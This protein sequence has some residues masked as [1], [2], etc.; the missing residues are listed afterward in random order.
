MVLK[1]QL[2]WLDS[3]NDKEKGDW[4]QVVG[5]RKNLM[6]VSVVN[7]HKCTKAWKVTKSTGTKTW[8]CRQNAYR[9]SS[10]L[11]Q[12]EMLKGERESGGFKTSGRRQ[13]RQHRAAADTTRDASSTKGRP[14]PVEARVAGCNGFVLIKREKQPAKE[15]LLGLRCVFLK[16]TRPLR[17]LT[18]LY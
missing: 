8:F 14:W 13:Q 7:A 6:I 11:G 17:D 9:S 5:V 16:I 3:M 15:N 4:G 2:L 1:V 12:V 18:L 10:E